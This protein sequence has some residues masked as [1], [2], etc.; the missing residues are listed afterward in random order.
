MKPNQFSWTSFETTPVIGIIRNL[1][2]DIIKEIAPLYRKAGLTTLEITMNTGDAPKIIQSLC[3]QYPELNIGAGTVLELADLQKALDAGASFIVTPVL[4]EEV[5]A[6]C[7]KNEVPVFP[8]AFTPTE[9][10]KAWK[11]G[12]S[13]VKVFPASQFGPSY[14]KELKAP[15][16][17]INLLPTG[18]ITLNNMETFFKAGATGLGMGSTLFDKNLLS[19]KDFAQ[20]YLRFEKVVTVAKSF[21]NS[22]EPR[23]FSKK[24][25]E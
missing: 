17:A 1:S 5:I 8:G 9:V 10:Y 4:N 22:I 24:Q 23:N 2:F 6:Y 14:L 25:N 7:V 16:N 13:A 18:G 21:K 12:A 11:Y 20:L 19:K 3:L 15:L